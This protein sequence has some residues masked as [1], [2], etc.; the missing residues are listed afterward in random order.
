MVKLQGK[1]W[2][3]IKVRGNFSV[4]KK[5][6]VW[7]RILGGTE[8][9]GR[10]ESMAK[11][12]MKIWEGITENRDLPNKKPGFFFKQRRVIFLFMIC[13]SS[14]LRKSLKGGRLFKGFF[15]GYAISRILR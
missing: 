4:G 2:E 7:G 15:T 9:M 1:I 8:N 10:N 13:A 11:L 14:P 6:K 3:G 12:L 5:V